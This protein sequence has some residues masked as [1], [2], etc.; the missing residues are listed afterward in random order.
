MSAPKST[1]STPHVPPGEIWTIGHWTCAQE[2]FLAPLR[3][4]DIELLADVRAHPA[5]RRN[6]QFGQD[7]MRRW[8]PDAGIDYVHLP[9]LGGRRRRQ[10]EVDPVRNAGWQQPSFKNYADYT[11]TDDYRNGIDRLTELATDRRTCCCAVSRCPGAAT[12]C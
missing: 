2:V 8:L 11:L 5:S 9:E 7:E 6:P 3:R 10:P 12:A 1:E 4:H